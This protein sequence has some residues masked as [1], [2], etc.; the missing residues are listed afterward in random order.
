MDWTAFIDESQSDQSQ[1]PGT[2]ILA[3]TIAGALQIDPARQRMTDLHIGK[4]GKVH[5]ND[6][7]PRRQQLI[8]ETVDQLQLG[9]PC[10][11]PVSRLDRKP[12][13]MRKL[14]LE[15]LCWELEQLSVNRMVLESRG[16]ADDRRDLNTLQSLRSKRS[17]SSTL[18]M[19]HRVGP[20][21]PMVWIA[22]APSVAQWSPT[23]PDVA[24]S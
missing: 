5:W 21:E 22:D 6:E 7:D 3:A 18:R 16:K 24:H 23:G 1:D 17:V 15:R 12:E 10:S 13:R 20:V 4:T 11:R 2:Y 9:A 19:E 14:C 8:I